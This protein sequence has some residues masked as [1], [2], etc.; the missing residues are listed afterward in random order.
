MMSSMPT[1][2]QG[3][4]TGQAGRLN[5]DGNIRQARPRRLVPQG[6]PPEDRITHATN[7]GNQVRVKHIHHHTYTTCDTR[8]SIRKPAQ[9][10]DQST[11]GLHTHTHNTQ[12]QLGKKQNTSGGGKVQNEGAEA[13]RTR[14]PTYG[15]AHTHT[16][17]YTSTCTQHSIH[18]HTQAYANTH[19]Q[20]AHQH[21]EDNRTQLKTP[22]HTGTFSTRKVPR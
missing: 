3:S 5:D 7:T 22:A 19:T 10:S 4:W 6:S 8:T 15:H 1:N 13:R 20:S 12:P 16:D 17:T 18:E 9:H 2:E 21:V 11:Y 14:T